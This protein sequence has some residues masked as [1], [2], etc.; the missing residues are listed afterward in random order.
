[1]GRFTRKG[2][3]KINW[4]VTLT[5]QTVPA[6]AE[7]NG[8]TALTP[9]LADISGFSFENNP[10]ATPDLATLFVPSI[11]GEDTA[12]DSTLTFYDDDASSVIRT[13]LAKSNAGYI[14]LCPYGITATKRCEVWPA[15]STGYNDEWT[16]GNEAAKANCKFA[17][18]A[19]PNQAAVIT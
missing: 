4:V 9:S 2:T 14:V 7:I 1:M 5:S 11:V 8:G 6:I 16:T 15:K 12:A 3:S 19:A 13:A 10:I 18:T 17:I